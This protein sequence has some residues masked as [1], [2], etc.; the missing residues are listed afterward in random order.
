[1]NALRAFEASARQQSFS[2]AAEELCV[3]HSAISQQVKQVEELLGTKLFHRTN[4]GVK[5]TGSGETLLPILIESFDRIGETL[6]GLIKGEE[7]STISVTTTPSFATKWL[8]PRLG[9]WHRSHDGLA[10]HLQPTLQFLDLT[11]DEADVG[12]RCGVPP[13]KGLVADLL[14]PIHMGPVCSPSILEGGRGLRTPRDVLEFT[15]IHA[16]I[17]GH[18][19]GE[20]WETWLSAVGLSDIGKLDGLSFHDPNLALQAAVDGLG[21]AMGYLELAEHDIST[22]RLV[23]PFDQIVQH[24]FSYYFVCSEARVDQPKVRAF[25][26]WIRTESN[27]DCEIVR[28]HLSN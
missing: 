12:I 4:R 13:W 3:T 25:R 27:A 26:E 16:D 7:K 15:L 8:L 23:C 10:I 19:L 5:L 28:R 2:K 24:R 21:M 20:E 17:T 1:M 6:D 14:L 9:R 22:S 11:K 18:E